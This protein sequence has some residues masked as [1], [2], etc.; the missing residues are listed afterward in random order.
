MLVQ[1]SEFAWMAREM[2]SKVVQ[3]F[4]KAWFLRKLNPTKAG[5]F[6]EELM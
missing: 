6:E 5:L 4:S 1:E 2:C 3:I